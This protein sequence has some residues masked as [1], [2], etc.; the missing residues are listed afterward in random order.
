MQQR[1][2]IRGAAKTHRAQYAL[3]C[4]NNARIV[5]S[6]ECLGEFRGGNGGA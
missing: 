3:A 1:I 4:S 5:R 2:H 6:P